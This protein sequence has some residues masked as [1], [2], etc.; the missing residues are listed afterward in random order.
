[1]T[2]V[3]SHFSTADCC[4]R[5]R[6]DAARSFATENTKITV[7]TLAS[8]PAVLHDPVRL[9]ALCSP[10]N[11]KNSVVE[12][13]RIAPDRVENAFVVE[14]QHFSIE[15]HGQ[16]A[17]RH[18]CSGHHRLILVGEHHIERYHGLFGHRSCANLTSLIAFQSTTFSPGTNC[19]GS[20]FPSQLSFM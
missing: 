10:S 7:F 16:R 14:L 9:R 1:M 17:I 11:E 20:S 19:D 2:W 4:G 13:L 6:V 15:R 12:T 3:C 8:T 5:L 18:Q